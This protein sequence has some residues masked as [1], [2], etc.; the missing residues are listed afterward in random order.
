MS[1]EPLV[2]PAITSALEVGFTQE[3]VDAAVER[4]QRE[5]KYYS[6]FEH[7]VSSLVSAMK[8]VRMWV[9]LLK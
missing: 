1:T 7:A 4:M 3:E 9:F 2:D 5:G 8:L 6:L